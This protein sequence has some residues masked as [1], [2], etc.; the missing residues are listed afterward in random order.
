MWGGL[1]GCTESSFEADS[2]P[3]QSDTVSP[4]SA[5]NSPSGTPSLATTQSTGETS[6]QSAAET[7]SPTATRSPTPHERATP[8]TDFYI[9]WPYDDSANWVE[10]SRL[11]QYPGTDEWAEWEPIYARTAKFTHVPTSEELASLTENSTQNEVP[12]LRLAVASK[13]RFH[14]E[15]S[16]TGVG[17]VDSV[18]D[19]FG[20]QFESGPMNDVDAIW[21]E[22]SSKELDS[23]ET[24]GSHTIDGVGDTGELETT[25][26]AKVGGELHEV[27]RVTFEA[28]GGLYGL[29][30]PEEQVGY[31]VGE[32]LPKQDTVTFHTA[33]QDSL[34]ISGFIDIDQLGLLNHLLDIMNKLDT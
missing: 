22:P 26:E 30:G 32:M 20:A 5:K 33:D 27:T 9:D 16:K 13:W 2:G 14:D 12:A 24:V 11:T 10:D 19:W 6:H 23:G 15:F 3:S 34:T 17:F 25:F 18:T 1:A 29:I 7:P 31:L 4:G 28:R 8:S 21:V